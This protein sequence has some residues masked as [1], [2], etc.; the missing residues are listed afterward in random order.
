MNRRHRGPAP[1]GVGER[2]R[3]PIAVALVAITLAA[4]VAA[5]T[6]P[7]PRPAGRLGQPPPT[8]RLVDAD[9]H[10]A[11]LLDERGQYV[12]VTRD[13]TVAWREPAGVRAFSSVSCLARCPDAVLSASLHSANAAAVADPAPRLVAGGQWRSLDVPAGTKRRILAADSGKEFVL[14]GGEPAGGG[15]IELHQPGTPVRR[16]PVGGFDSTWHPSADG[17]HALAITSLVGDNEA[18]WL[19][20]T[21]QGWQP[22]GATM[23]VTGVAACVTPDGSRALLLGQ[24][25]AVLDRAGNQRPLTDL[26]LAG[27]CAWARSGGIVA[28]L[29]ATGQGPRSRLRVVDDKYVVRWQRDVAGAVRMTADP[30]GSRVAYQTDRVLHEIHTQ[31]GVGL[32]TIPGVQAAR[33]DANGDLVTIADDGAVTWR[34]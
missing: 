10:G 29:S 17:R 28:E 15:W 9:P 27:A 2:P 32:R 11:V 3:T 31:R 18:R 30:T 33:Y 21:G 34:R 8:A 4:A 26:E 23:R 19:T 6:Q 7:S 22:A 5:C 1:H 16:L 25:P 12:G 24:R 14:A 20:R 13:G